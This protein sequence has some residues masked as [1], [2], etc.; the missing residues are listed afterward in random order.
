MLSYFRRTFER[1]VIGDSVPSLLAWGKAVPRPLVRRLQGD[2]FRRTVI[3]A[4]RHQNFFARK[5]KERGLDASRI[6][7]AA[8]LGD[9]FT[10]PED[11]LSLPAEDFLCKPPQAVFETT[12]TS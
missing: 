5:L 7:Q 3:Y 6:R 2:A 12:G 10:T 11:I 9:L 8:D 1:A 4:A